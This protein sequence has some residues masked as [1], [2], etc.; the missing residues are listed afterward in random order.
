LNDCAHDLPLL[1]VALPLLQQR[2]QDELFTLG[3]DDVYLDA[4]GLEEAVDA[5]DA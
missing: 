3:V 5:V 4:P 2:L 1:F